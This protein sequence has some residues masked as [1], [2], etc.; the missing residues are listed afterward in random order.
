VATCPC[1]HVHT[2]H[3][4]VHTH[5]HTHGTRCPRVLPG[6]GPSGA[7][8]AWS[9]QPLQTPPCKLIHPPPRIYF[10]FPGKRR[11]DSPV[12]WSALKFGLG[13]SNKS[14]PPVG[15]G[16]R[17][18]PLGW[19]MTR[20]RFLAVPRGTAQR[21]APGSGGSARLTAHGASQE[22]P[23]PPSTAHGASHP[24]RLRRA[25]PTAPGL[26]RRR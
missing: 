10:P 7:G 3:A 8:T 23:R 13:A 21:D 24:T 12:K 1:P 22:Q 15:M 9:F 6:L 2:Q 18:W 5:V 20:L 17:G 26:H 11:A 14:H 19:S 25:R 4:R 16:S